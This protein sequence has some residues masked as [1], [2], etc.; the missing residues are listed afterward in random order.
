MKKYVIG[1]DE[2]I[3]K[4]SDCIRISQ[5]GLHEHKKPIGVFMFIGSSGVG[6]TELAKT[7]ARIMF[8]DENAMLRIDMSEYMERHSVSRLIGAPPGYIGYDES[9]MLTENVRR[10]PYQVILLDEIEK[11]HREVCNVLLQVMDEGN[12]TDSHGRKV[13]FRNTIIIMTSNLGASITST[14]LN[15]D[16]D[17]ESI[18]HMD[19]LRSH[20]PPEFI[21]RIDD[22]IIFNRLNMNNMRP[23]CD[24]QIHKIELMLNERNIKFNIDNASRDWL[25]QIGYDD[26]YGARP[27]KRI[28]QV[29]LL[30]PLASFFLSNQ[31]QD[32]STISVT[33][34]YNTS[35]LNFSFVKNVDHND[36]LNSN[37]DPKSISSST[38]VV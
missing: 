13:D 34:D 26:I 29:Q 33:F 38:S 31:I 24:L 36:N 11:A 22:I 35:K 30:K 3:D 16:K 2:A 6:K 4:I 19:A 25:A 9:G 5:A 21:N 7:I 23:I 17:E 8:E 20:F 18:R 27:L 37:D 12:L 32:G 28:I 14:S 15:I 10:R 1:Q